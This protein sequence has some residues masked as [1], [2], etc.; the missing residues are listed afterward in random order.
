MS[1]KKIHYFCV[2]LRLKYLLKIVPRSWIGND[3]ITLYYLVPNK[4]SV[5]IGRYKNP[6]LKALLSRITVEKFC[7]DSSKMRD[8]NNR[9]IVD[10]GNIDAMDR[11]MDRLDNVYFNTKDT[12]LNQVNGRLLVLKDD[13]KLWIKHRIAW[14]NFDVSLLIEVSAWAASSPKSRLRG[15]EVGVIVDKKTYCM[16]LII[17]YA[18]EKN[19]SVLSFR[20]WK[21]MKENGLIVF[22]Y[23]L[24]QLVAMSIIPLF[25]RKSR[26]INK[27]KSCICTFHDALD[28]FCDYSRKNYNLFWYPGSG[29]SSD[30]ISIFSRNSGEM[31]KRGIK[32][33]KDAG[34]DLWSCDGFMKKSNR[35][36]PRHRCSLQA[37]RLFF[38][39]VKESIRLLFKVKTMVQYEQWKMLSLL[40]MSLP[41]WEDFFRLNNV[42]VLFKSGVLFS[43]LDIAAKLAKTVTI[44]YQYSNHFAS[45]MGH[46]D[47]C[48]VFFV[49]GKAYERAYQ[50]RHSEVRNF[51]QTGYI[52]DY[53]FDLLGGKATALK[54]DFIGEEAKF[55]LSVFDENLNI[56]NFAFIESLVLNM[57]SVYRALFEY[58]VNNPTVAIIVKTK[59]KWN[60]NF[61]KS[62]ECTA[63]LIQRLE[64]EGRV[65]FLETEKFPAEA[66]KAS[67]LSIGMT[68]NSAAALEC[69]LAGVPSIFYDSAMIGPLNPDYVPGKNKVIF[70]DIKTMITSIDHY[71]TTKDLSNGF[72]DWSPF[73]SEKDPFRD[74]KANQRIGFYIK[75]LLSGMDSGFKKETAITN[76]NKI[77]ADKFGKDKVVSTDFSDCTDKKRQERGMDYEQVV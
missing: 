25:D 47:S 10:T 20:S 11:I 34:F 52:F 40:L 70:D 36:I 28:N 8:S 44:S 30:Q 61:L 53:A 17:D 24:M 75:T 63:G 29:I 58:A 12:L 18:R 13:L 45:D 59:K 16:G 5:W 42:K 2:H 14:P 69:W 73:I 22:F 67:D 7:I 41:Y 33:I 6:I 55:V 27:T 54:K 26:R 4:A 46:H 74:G 39:N 9:S 56:A 49:W 3:N 60:E 15:E 21:G 50:H 38:G 19:L 51:I 62:S 77:Y 48:D 65:K 64:K 31:K 32:K 35:L 71:R 72:A 43:D 23:Q 37:F 57:F 1:R 68:S 76:T 66:G